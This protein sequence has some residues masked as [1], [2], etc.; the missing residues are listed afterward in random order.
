MKQK[1]NKGIEE[2]KNAKMEKNSTIFLFLWTSR[3][4]V[5]MLSYESIPIDKQEQYDWK[6]DKNLDGK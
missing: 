3:I 4:L 1:T 2:S 6:A 5:D